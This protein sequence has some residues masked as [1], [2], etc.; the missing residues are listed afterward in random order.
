MRMQG[1]GW[2]PILTVLGAIL[3]PTIGQSGEITPKGKILANTLDDMH[4]EKLWLAKHIVAWKTGEP[5]DQPV[6]DGKAHTHCS[7]FVA[8]ACM[9]CDVYILRPPEHGTVLLA[10][11]QYDWL[12]DSGKKK[13]W[14]TVGSATEAQHLANQGVMVVA[15]FRED[16]PKK[17]G[18]IAIVRPS[19][20]S[21]Q[22]IQEEGPQ[23][24]QAGTSNHQSTSLKEGFKHHPTAWKEQKVRYYSHELIGASP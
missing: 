19:T 9:R 23:I 5:L 22:K 17:A 13:G 6:A 1:F 8:S 3:V 15:S 24:I 21:E 2:T 7:A 20:K 12:R 11:A 10:N 14:K 16:D 18:H 4:V